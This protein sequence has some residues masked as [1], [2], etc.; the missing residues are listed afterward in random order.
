MRILFFQILEKL[1]R[2]SSDY[3]VQSLTISL[4][5][6]QFQRRFSRTASAVA[7]TVNQQRFA[8]FLLLRI[9]HIRLDNCHRR[10]GRIIVA[11]RS[12]VR[13][14]L[15]SVYSFP[16]KSLVREFILHI[17]SEFYSHEIFSAAFFNYLRI[18]CRKTEN[19]G[20]PHRFAMLAEFLFKE[21]FSVQ[22]LS[23]QR[24]SAG[25][26]A[27]V[28]RPHTALQFHLSVR[29]GNFDFFVKLGR[30]FFN[31]LK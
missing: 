19:V 2:M 31:P 23:Y 25:Q 14:Y 11:L 27:I 21:F 8:Y 12:H 28:F 10:S 1:N 9:A 7:D 18:G 20:K 13:N 4:S 5:V 16:Y 15:A 3:L 29:N 24:F 22:K 26:I 6:K 30:F 17:P